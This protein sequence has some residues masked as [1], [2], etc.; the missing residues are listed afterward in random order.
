M[1]GIHNHQ[2]SSTTYPQQHTQRPRLKRTISIGDINTLSSIDMMY[3]ERVLKPDELYV[4]KY[5]YR[6][7][8]R[9]I[10]C[11]E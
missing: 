6:R 4:N 1:K 9:R 10:T 5:N 11:N 3:T 2:Q 7:D 8:I